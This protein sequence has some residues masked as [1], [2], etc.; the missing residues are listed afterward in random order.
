MR[1]K[2]NNIKT[3]ICYTDKKNFI[4]SA[5]SL[6]SL[7]EF[8]KDKTS[9]IEKINLKY[10]IKEFKTKSHKI[11]KERYQKI[12]KKLEHKKGEK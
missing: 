5:S 2:R 11:A 8:K 1:K 6:L 9:S 3:I 12:L 4:W 7:E 10:P